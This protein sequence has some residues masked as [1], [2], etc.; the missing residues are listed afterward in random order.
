[1]RENAAI[2]VACLLISSIACGDEPSKAAASK[3]AAAPVPPPIL[4]NPYY[5]QD[6]PITDA[7]LT[8]FFHP[9]NLIF[10]ANTFLLSAMAQEKSD[11]QVLYV[12]NRTIL[13]SS[14]Q[15]YPNKTF[16][17]YIAV[18]Q[19]NLDDKKLYLRIS[20][21]KKDDALSVLDSS[22]SQYIEGVLHLDDY[23]PVRASFT[24]NYKNIKADILANPIWAK[25]IAAIPDLSKAVSF[26]PQTLTAEQLNKSVKKQEV[27]VDPAAIRATV[28]INTF[29][30]GTDVD[31]FLSL[32]EVI[33]D[34]SYLQLTASDI[35]LIFHGKIDN[36]AN[37]NIEN[38]ISIFKF[39]VPTDEL[40][41]YLD[42]KKNLE[43]QNSAPYAEV[44]EIHRSL[45]TIL[46]K[47][48]VKLDPAFSNKEF[49]NGLQYIFNIP[50]LNYML[51]QQ[52]I[53][54][55]KAGVNIT[56]S[57]ADAKDTAKTA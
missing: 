47:E 15:T 23:F 20:L 42:I 37:A 36:K 26:V 9:A 2:L 5:N 55:P 53:R 57:P 18:Y 19:V 35:S 54:T 44:V 50:Y 28:A 27:A 34:I 32:A 56:V 1:M 46:A 43:I 30:N 22:F 49:G 21:E 10:Y 6:T 8:D 3:A 11:V 4:V 38:Y 48:R 52:P 13:N 51:V 12:G 25:L 31:P 40:Y 39:V 33:N 14:P 41:V 45:D 7:K 24:E 16:L 29:K 17:G